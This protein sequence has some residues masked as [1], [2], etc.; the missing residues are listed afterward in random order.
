LDVV[1]DLAASVVGR[2]AQDSLRMLAA[3]EGEAVEL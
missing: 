2:H 3:F 1:D